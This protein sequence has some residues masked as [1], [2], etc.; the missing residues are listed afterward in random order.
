M[1]LSFLPTPCEDLN[2]RVFRPHSI[3]EPFRQKD[4][5]EGDRVL[6]SIIKLRWTCHD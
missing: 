4:L 2:N 1:C 6:N 3:F 5:T